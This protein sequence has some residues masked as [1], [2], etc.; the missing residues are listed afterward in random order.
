M[1]RMNS[2]RVI[3][4]CLAT[5][6]LVSCSGKSRVSAEN[7]GT[8][9]GMSAKKIDKSYKIGVDDN[10]QVNVWRNPE[11]SVNAP[12]RPDG[13]ISVPLI[14]DV[15]AGG[16]TS[17][18][19]ASSI[20]NKLSTYIRDPNVTVIVTGLR[21]HEYLSRIRV[22]GAVR[23]PRSAPYRDGMTVLDAILEAGG[24]NDF[25]APNRTKLYRKNGTT[26]EV[27]PIK[28]ENILTKGKLETNEE[29][30]PGDVI[31]VPERLF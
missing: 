6:V 8:S 12:V 1:L 31:T 22:T 15:M 2:G 7:E 4:V 29:L 17:E 16:F 13:M 25:A 19:V 26:M 5:M 14:G 30:K 9:S 28:L 27:I 21:S 3:V 20:K 18:E 10:L 24:V 11:V 23:Q